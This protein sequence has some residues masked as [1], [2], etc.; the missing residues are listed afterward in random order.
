[1]GQQGQRV[2]AAGREPRA[3]R[4]VRAWRR[5]LAPSRALE[6]AVCAM[7]AGVDSDLKALRTFPESIAKGFVWGHPVGDRRC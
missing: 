1:V 4:A 6:R 3:G 5:A 2:A 7:A